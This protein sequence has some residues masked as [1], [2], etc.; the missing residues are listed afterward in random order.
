MGRFPTGVTVVSAVDGAGRP[1]GFTANAFT[2]VSLDPPLVLVCVDGASSSHDLLV[3][4][5]SFVV[6][7]LES[8]QE[9]LARRFSRD[10]PEER[11]RDVPARR[12]TLGHPVLEDGLAWM[13]CEIE[14]V[15]PAGDHSIVVARVTQVEAGPGSPLVFHEGR[16]SALPG[17]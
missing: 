7:V 5:G 10:V 16:F 15:H 13:E 1:F 8:G 12:S 2:S 3:Q 9:G 17:A 14:Q 6:N 4:R 11:F